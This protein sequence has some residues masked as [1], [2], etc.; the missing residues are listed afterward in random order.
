MNNR[1]SNQK[2]FVLVHGAWHGNWCWSKV[3]PLLKERGYTVLTPDL[4]GHFHNKKDFHDVTLQSYV[5][6][7][8]HLIN[9][10]ESPVILVGHSM[11]GVVI[12][13]V[14]QHIPQKIE[15]L[16]YVSAFIPQHNGSL[17]EESKKG[18]TAEFNEMLEINQQEMSININSNQ[19]AI[20]FFYNNCSEETIQFALQ[21]IQAQP[22]SPFSDKITISQEIFQNISKTYIQCLQDNAIPLEEQLRMCEAINCSVETLNTDHSPFF[23]RPNELVDLICKDYKN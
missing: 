9:S 15:R 3:A 4:P 18:A 2:T 17:V 22:L 21:H 8:I 16:I 5:D 1:H 14:A 7:V 6:A 19:R 23:S 20:H 13:Q 12:T 10:C 11:A